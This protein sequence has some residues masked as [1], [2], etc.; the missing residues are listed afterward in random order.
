MGISPDTATHEKDG[1]TVG[2]TVLALA[3]LDAFNAACL[4]CSRVGGSDSVGGHRQK[5]YLDKFTKF[6]FSA[7]NQLLSVARQ[8]VNEWYPTYFSLDALSLD[9]NRV[10]RDPL[11]ERKGTVEIHIMSMPRRLISVAWPWFKD[12]TTPDM[13]AIYDC[14]AAE[15]D[16][17]TNFICK[18]CW[19]LQLWSQFLHSVDRANEMKYGN[20]WW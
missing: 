20:Y 14:Y 13:G 15:Y 1:R 12:Y 16:A 3:R 9:S 7:L 5:L 11:V 4:T 2:E 19:P 18:L 6:L 17:T 8:F 10:S